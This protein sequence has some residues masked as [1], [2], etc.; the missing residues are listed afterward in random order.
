MRALAFLVGAGLVGTAT[1][2]EATIYLGL[3]VDNGTI[4]TIGDDAGTGSLTFSGNYG[5]FTNSIIAQGYPTMVQPALQT[6]S[7]DTAKASGA[8]STLTI[9]ITQTDLS[10]I[11]GGLLSSFTSNSF[12][13]AALS[14]EE[15]TMLSASNALFGG[16]LLASQT[17]TGL[18][19][20][21]YGTAVGNLIGPFSETTKYVINAGAGASSFNDTINITSGAV[22]EPASWALMISGFGLVGGAL[23][24][25][26]RSI[27]FEA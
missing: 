5:G 13:G 25:S 3:Q 14:V 1:Q 10:P 18:G 20:K 16:T 8:A 22:P 17:F 12:Q 2:A 26:R 7:I 27:A 6:A 23:R 24:M 4:R 11:S 19:S 21:D 15:S 9:Y